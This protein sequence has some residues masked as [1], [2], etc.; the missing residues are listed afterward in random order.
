MEGAGRDQA[1]GNAGC[2]QRGSS[3]QSASRPAVLGGYPL[4][5]KDW[6]ES[7]ALPEKTL[8]G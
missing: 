2:E 4:T 8:E 3:H 1:Q 6:Q 7:P 5:I